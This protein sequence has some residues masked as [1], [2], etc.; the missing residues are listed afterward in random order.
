MAGLSV[1]IPLLIA[2]VSV[3]VSAE[4]ALSTALV[5]GVGIGMSYVMKP[6]MKKAS[7]ETS[8]R[9][10]QINTCESG[11]PL[12]LVYG[13]CKVGINR[14]FVGTSG[15][16][17]KYLHIIGNIC[18]GEIQGI[19]E[20]DGVPQIFLGDDIYTKFGDKFHYELFTGSPTQTVCS[21][22]HEAIPEWN[23]PKKNTAYIYIRLEYDSDLF[24]G[25]PDVTM[26]I[27]GLKT[28]YDPETGTSGFTRNPALIARDFITRA[29]GGMGIAGERLDDDYTTEAK[30][31]CAEKGWLCD[32]R[33]DSDDTASD[34]LEAI[35]ITFRGSLLFSADKYK[36]KFSDMDYESPVLTITDDLVVEVN[37]ETSL[38][39]TQPS[40]FDTPN[41]VRLKWTNPE[42]KYV[43]DEYQLADLDAQA[44]DGYVREESYDVVG[45]TSNANVM[46]MANYLLE[47]LRI[48]KTATLSAHPIVMQ[49]E[50]NDLV[51]LTHKRPG[52]SNK[53][54]RASTVSFDFDGN[55]ALSLTEEDAA[56]YDDTYNLASHSFYDTTLP[57]PRDPVPSVSNI[58]ITEEVYFFRGRSFTR[59]VVDWTPPANY[60]WFDYC[61]VWVN[62]AGAGWKYMT[63]ARDEYMIDP[64]Q[65]GE[66][67]AI[68]LVVN[69]IWGTKEAFASASSGSHTVSGSTGLPPDPTGLTLLASGD[70]ISIFA[71]RMEDPDIAFYEVRVGASWAAGLY[72][73]ANET[74]NI[75]LVG[76][77]PGTL[78]VWMAIAKIAIDGTI[79]YS[80]NPISGQVTSF[81]PANYTQKDSWVWDYDGI[82]THN[83]TEH[84]TYEST[85]ALRCSHTDGVLTGTWLS[86]TYDLGSVQTVR[87]WGDFLTGVDAAEMTW[88]GVFVQSKIPFTLK[89]AAGEYL[90]TAAG[91]QLIVSALDYDTWGVRIDEGERWF[92]VWTPVAAGGIT[93]TLHY[94]TVDTS[95]SI[96]GFE[97][98]APEVSARYV[99]VEISITDPNAATHNYIKQLTMKTAYW[100]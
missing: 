84:T 2:D 68:K 64:V 11:I 85:D 41:A 71:D 18:E 53:I 99:A 88:G 51:Y 17:N 3:I 7:T 58:I 55:V 62:V 50:P 91:D 27:D 25:L 98:S 56:L 22:L 77:R 35:L 89:T 6:Q 93:A 14:V 57:N 79:L 9:G 59:L 26:V 96:A 60:P 1:E 80:E 75:R 12:P 69:S 42:N 8:S 43:T 94:G 24:S 52:W 81:G 54:M 100:S 33:L 73:G 39:I 47:R 74:P 70:T 19:V 45:M 97:L 61:D 29:R 34:M 38:T 28:I 49:V 92:Q 87:I 86:P 78:T 48:N 63:T 40:I 32:L 20:V 13:R 83:N 31:Y 72:A 46:K 36:I 44:S 4:A 15:L 37:G 95:N 16:D 90:K 30:T 65:E 76:V 67:Y 66:T 82:G 21:T 5:L 23:D 10:W